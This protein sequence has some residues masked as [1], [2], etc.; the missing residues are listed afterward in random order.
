MNGGHKVE[1]FEVH[2]VHCVL[3][4]HN[5]FD[6]KGDHVTTKRKLKKKR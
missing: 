6:P 2:C 5:D 4:Y 3:V 1:L